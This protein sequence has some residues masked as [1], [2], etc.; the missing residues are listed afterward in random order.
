SNE[1]TSGFFNI[2]LTDPFIRNKSAA[3]SW[4]IGQEVSQ[5]LFDEDEARFDTITTPGA[6]ST[7]LLNKYRGVDYYDANNPN[8]YVVSNNL[9]LYRLADIYLLRAEARFKNGNEVGALDDLNVVRQRA[10]LAAFD[11]W[12]DALFNEIFD[13]RRRELIG[14]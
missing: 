3:S 11:G 6:S 13:E 8:T 14:E 2:F 9:V 1:A 12:G 4:T 7:L 5:L 10:K